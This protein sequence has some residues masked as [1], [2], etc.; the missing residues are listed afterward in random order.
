MCDRVCSGG[1]HSLARDECL[2]DTACDINSVREKIYINKSHV[3][4]SRV[5]N[6]GSNSST[7]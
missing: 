4:S 3:W 1:M 2:C 5:L 7:L 6:R